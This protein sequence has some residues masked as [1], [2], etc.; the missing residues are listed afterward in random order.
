LEQG[1]T[2][3]LSVIHGNSRLDAPDLSKDFSKGYFYDVLTDSGESIAKLME[4]NF[5]IKITVGKEPYEAADL[6]FSEIIY[7]GY[8]NS[9]NMTLK[10]KGNPNDPGFEVFISITAINYD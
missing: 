4:E 8:E 2:V 9:K 5:K 1:K 3:S 6:K 10:R 7:G